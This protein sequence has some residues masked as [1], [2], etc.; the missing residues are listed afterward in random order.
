MNSPEFCADDRVSLLLFFGLCTLQNGT[1]YDLPL[2]ER[3]LLNHI[4]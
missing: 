4:I 2:C 1:S 3:S